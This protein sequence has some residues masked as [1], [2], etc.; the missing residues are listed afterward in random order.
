MLAERLVLPS[1][2]MHK[3]GYRTLHHY[4]WRG[5]DYN[6]FITN[7]FTSEKIMLLKIVHTS[8]ENIN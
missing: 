1:T 8:L 7:E 4:L 5:G 3:I 6:N 2:G